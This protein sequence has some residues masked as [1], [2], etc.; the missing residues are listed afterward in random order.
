MRC[1]SNICQLEIRGKL[2]LMFRG[3]FSEEFCDSGSDQC[4]HWYVISLADL[5]ER[6]NL[7][8]VEVEDGLHFLFAGAHAE[9]SLR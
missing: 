2:V 4:T 7:L 8:C 1:V 6:L 9:H 5:L 3:V